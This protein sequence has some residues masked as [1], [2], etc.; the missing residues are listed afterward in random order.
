[1][2]ITIRQL[3]K[4]KPVLEK[5][6]PQDV[7]VSTAYDLTKIVRF[8]DE[9]L[10]IFTSLRKK[11][12]TKFGKIDDKTKNIDIIKEKTEQFNK[13]ITELLNKEIELKIKKIRIS[14]LGKTVNLSTNDLIKIELMVEK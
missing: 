4:M 8:F 3:L 12:Y 9:E 2:K 6:I 7:P 11:I 14:T 13:A 5:I 10:K 1:M